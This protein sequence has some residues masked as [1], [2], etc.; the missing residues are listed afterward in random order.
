MVGMRMINAENL[1]LAVAAVALGLQECLGINLIAI[2]AIV[3]LIGVLRLPD[4]GG[5]PNLF[6]SSVHSQQQTA[7]FLGIALL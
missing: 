2:A 7:T 3:I 4:I 1:P 6:N 5:G